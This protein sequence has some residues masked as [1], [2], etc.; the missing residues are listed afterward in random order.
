MGQVR[1]ALAGSHDVAAVI[2]EPTGSSFGLVP[3]SAEFAQEL[4]AETE[5]AGV[6]LIFDEV[7]TGF[8]VSPG[9][10]Q[11][12][13]GV[14]PDLTSLA[15]ILAGGMPG[16]AV[17]GR[18]DILDHLDVKASRAAGREKIEHQGTYNANPVAAATGAAALELIEA[19]NPGQQADASA[20]ALR[21]GLNAV[22]ERAGLPWVV[23]G[24]SSGFHTF[25]NP[26]GLPI[27]P[28]RFDPA[29]HDYHALK[30]QPSELVRKLRLAMLV[31]GV[32]LNPRLGGF[33][34][35]AHAKEDV[36]A[37]VEAFAEAIRMLDAEGELRAERQ[38]AA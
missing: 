27:G 31:N 25:L 22:I 34:S 14:R 6:L 35:V 21:D 36:E 12:A 23:Y 9:G 18:Q 5:R 7:V 1:A 13:Y 15:K 30:A 24:T 37:T 2:L 28:G 4:R 17:V 20:A 10:A 32:D 29:R 3:L 33:L 11:A 8:R 38:T 16:G 19:S 26:D